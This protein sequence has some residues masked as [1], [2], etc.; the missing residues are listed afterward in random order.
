MQIQYYNMNSNQKY[1]K[2]TC[3]CECKTYRTCKKDCIWNPRTCTCENSN[4][5]KSINNTSAFEYVI[6]SYLLWVLHQ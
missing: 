3:Q 4:Y 1:N 2:K 5:L 6:K